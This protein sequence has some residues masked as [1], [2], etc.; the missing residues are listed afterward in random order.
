MAG[1]SAAVAGRIKAGAV[2]RGA[3]INAASLGIGIMIGAHSRLRLT[4]GANQEAGRNF[5]AEHLFCKN[6]LYHESGRYARPL[7]RRMVCSWTCVSALVAWSCTTR[8]WLRRGH[9][10]TP[11]RW[12]AS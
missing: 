3:L 11:A 10:A 1:R 6:K 7:S 9:L 4:F 8:S 2:E 12:Q 5:R